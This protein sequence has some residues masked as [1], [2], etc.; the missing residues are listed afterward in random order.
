LP[1]AIRGFV[2]TPTYRVV[3]ER[4]QVQ[5]YAVLEDSSPCLVEDDRVRPRILRARAARVEVRESAKRTFDGEPVVEVLVRLPREVP[6]LREKLEAAGIPCFEA[7]V[8]FA[9]R[10][11]ID[12]GIAGGFTVTGS[13]VSWGRSG[14]ACR[15]PELRPGRWVPSLRVLSLDIE[16]S[17]DARFIYSIALCAAGFRRVL[18]VYDRPVAGAEVLRDEGALLRRFLDCVGEFDPD[19]ITGWNVVDFDLAVVERQCRAHRI[20]CALGRT[21]EPLEIRRERSWGRESRAVV[22]GRVVMDALSLT[23]ASSVRL[24]D[25]RLETAAQALLGRGKL[26]G[27]ADRAAEIEAAYRSDPERLVAYNAN[28]A[29]LVLELLG[30]TKLLDLA[31]SRSLLT[32]MPL[33]RFGAAI[34]AV[35]SLYLGAAHRRG[36][37]VPSV[38]RSTSAARIAGGFVMDSVP[39]LY[40]N[41][42]VFDFKSLYPSII[43]TFNIDP[44]TH[45][46]AP[47]RVCKDEV[48][49]APNGACFLRS[50]QGILPELVARLAAERE[51]ARQRGEKVAAN[52]IKILMNSLYGVLGSSASRLFSPEVANAIT[53]FGQYLIRFAAQ[54]VGAQGLAV[55]YGDTDSLFVDGRE[56]DPERAREV[57]MALA[58]AVTAAVGEAVQREFGC[59][60][61]LELEFERLYLR[62]FLPEV[63]RGRTGR[64]KRYAG[65]VA[66]PHG[67]E[68]EF[69]GL[70]SVRRDWT[71]ASEV[72]QRELLDR[73]FHDRPVDAFV[74]EFVARLRRGELDELLVY[75]KAVRKDLAA[76][77]KTTPPHVRAA[78]MR[79]RGGGIVDYVM[80][81]AG[82]QPVEATSAPLD[83]EHY[84]EHQIRPVANA[85]LRFL[86][87]DFGE[88]VDRRKQLELF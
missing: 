2:L 80:T 25:Y 65:L 13:W 53:Y 76:Y 28:D 85:V 73:V 37:V 36:M 68:I 41:I 12:R 74:Q 35:D 57:G 16:T 78:R 40:R 26:L 77:T 22:R 27:G 8:R 69:V 79:G 30:E 55:I 59:Q 7:D 9:L 48:V 20:P 29:Q 21:D 51:S 1:D 3:G 5:L 44:L 11:L 14:R 60:S 75:K 19:V 39:G 82:P 46:P 88:L 24:E 50:P 43:R 70:E 63:R 33:D 66:T 42:L 64:K 10:Y 71:E 31:V 84:I 87:R 58:R 54:F 18:L 6:R 34:A 38:P 32:G 23:H 62:F 72:F 52:A 15:N 17:P 47:A 86:G 45:V 83:H 49:R 67:E 4:P 81:T 61:F 56:P